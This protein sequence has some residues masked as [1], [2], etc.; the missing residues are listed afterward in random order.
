MTD[1]RLSK[2]ESLLTVAILILGTLFFSFYTPHKATGARAD[3]ATIKSAC[4][5]TPNKEQCYALAFEKLTEQK[6]W[7][8]S[9][10]VL[11]ALQQVEPQ[12]RGCHFIAHSISR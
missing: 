6:D 10:E 3:V 5:S 2:K 7:N 9:F 4:A 8:Y 1:K 11:H 12:S